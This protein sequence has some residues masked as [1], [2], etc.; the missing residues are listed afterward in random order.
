MKYQ[1][2]LIYE[3][4]ISYIFT[5]HFWSIVNGEYHPSG[6]SHLFTEHFWAIVDGEYQSQCSSDIHTYSRS[7]S[8]ASRMVKNMFF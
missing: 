5:E 6:P 8:G 7:T 2:F 1:L 3:L 4:I